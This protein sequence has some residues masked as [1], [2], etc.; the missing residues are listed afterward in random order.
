MSLAHTSTDGEGIKKSGPDKPPAVALAVELTY[1][2]LR[3]TQPTRP[4][5]AS[6]MPSIASEAGS[7]TRCQ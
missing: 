3:R 4:S 6:A 5:A 7:G 1:T 2:R